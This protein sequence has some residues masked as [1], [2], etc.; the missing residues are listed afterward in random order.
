MYDLSC[1]PVNDDVK[2]SIL[3]AIKIVKSGEESVI[4]NARTGEVVAK[5]SDMNK[6]KK[7]KS[8]KDLVVLIGISG[9]NKCKKVKMMVNVCEDG[10]IIVDLLN[11]EF[12]KINPSGEGM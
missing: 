8:C 12:K 2:T 11:G 3:N 1:I 10:S 5:V 9:N 7:I 6:S 4:I